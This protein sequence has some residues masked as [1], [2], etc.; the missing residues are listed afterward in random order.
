MVWHDIPS[1]FFAPEEALAFIRL[2]VLRQVHSLFQT[3]FSTE[4]DL[5]L[6]SLSILGVPSF[7]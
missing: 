7:P 1:L 4:C 6:L 5:V 3:E 2:S